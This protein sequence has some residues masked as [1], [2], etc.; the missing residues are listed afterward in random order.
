ANKK[1]RRNIPT[2]YNPLAIDSRIK[3][4]QNVIAAVHVP[5]AWQMPEGNTAIPQTRKLKAQ[6]DR[7]VSA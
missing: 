1:W 2:A 6:I 4:N 7:S 5:G 3:P